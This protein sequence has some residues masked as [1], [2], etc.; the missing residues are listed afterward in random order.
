MSK[1]ILHIIAVALGNAAGYLESFGMSDFF[2][3]IRKILL[4]AG[5]LGGAYFSYAFFYATEPLPEFLSQ[6]LKW[7]G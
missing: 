1:N 4:I 5:T 2:Y 6:L 3:L 7:F